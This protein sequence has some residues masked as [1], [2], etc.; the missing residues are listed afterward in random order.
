MLSAETLRPLAS[1]FRLMPMPFWLTVGDT[2]KFLSC[3]RS[4]TSGTGGGGVGT[5]AWPGPGAGP[6]TGAWA[7]GPTDPEAEGLADVRAGICTRYSDQ[8]ESLTKV[9]GITSHLERRMPAVTTWPG[10]S[11]DV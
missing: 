11:V 6:W 10:K 9:A 4:D 2:V 1:V 7:G 3:S 8:P 5:G